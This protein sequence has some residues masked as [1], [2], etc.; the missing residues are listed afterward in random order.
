MKPFLVFAG[1]YYYP[2]GGMNDFIGSFVSLKQAHA[3]FIT[4]GYDW[5]QIVCKESVLE[6][7][8]R[9]GGVWKKND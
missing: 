3:A 2:S 1:D 7:W 8:F 6:W 5:A 4:Q 9:N